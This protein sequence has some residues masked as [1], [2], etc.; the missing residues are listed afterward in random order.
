MQ[1]VLILKELLRHRRWL[2]I[3]PVFVA[4]VVG[5][6][7]HSLAPPTVQW[8]AQGQMFV[9][10]SSSAISNSWEAFDGLGT[11]APVYANMMTSSVV[12]QY[13]AKASG[14][15]AD[16]IAVTGPV[17]DTGLRSGHAPTAPGG[18]YS[19][20]LD[21][22]IPQPIIRIT[23]V[24]PTRQSALAL[25]NGAVQGLSQYVTHL[26]TTENIPFARQIVIRDLGYPTALS[27][28]NGLTTMIIVP[29]AI[30]VFFVWCLLVLFGARFVE[31]WKGERVPSGSAT[32]PAPSQAGVGAL[33]RHSPS[34][35][36]GD[37]L[38][39]VDGDPAAGLWPRPPLPP[40]R[41]DVHSQ[42]A[43]GP[44]TSEQASRLDGRS[45]ASTNGNG[46]GAAAESRLKT[47]G[48]RRFIR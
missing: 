18:P 1:L 45:A 23:A 25:A 17:D 21:V 41:R 14:I 24:A 29:V 48:G 30:A 4:V 33:T 12:L 2:A 35:V 39:L 27:E 9:D 37:S 11:R 36:N 3:G 26:A 16:E 34:E 32:P 31:T 44:S 19:L 10:S 43:A 22:T 40:P 20:T 38:K 13:V 7:V 42:E 8:T 46:N 5:Y 28:A 6:A 15:P 47:L